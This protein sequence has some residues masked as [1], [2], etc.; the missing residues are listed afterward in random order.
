[1]AVNRKETVL[2]GQHNLAQGNPDFSGDAL[3]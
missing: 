1:M 3:G 2:K